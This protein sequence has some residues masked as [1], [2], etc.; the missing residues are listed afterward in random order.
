M[1]KKTFKSLF[2]YFREKKSVFKNKDS[3]SQNLGPKSQKRVKRRLLSKI[4]Y[5]GILRVGLGR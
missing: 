4:S 1:P 5:L 2:N 3:A